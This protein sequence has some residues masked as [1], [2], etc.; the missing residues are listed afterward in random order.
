[1]S[2]NIIYL[3]EQSIFSET[4]K[5]MVLMEGGNFY[6]Y[7]SW[8]EIKDQFADL[9]ASYIF[10]DLD[11]F[12]ISTVSDEIKKIEAVFFTESDNKEYSWEGKL[13]IE[14]KPLDVL[15]FRKHLQGLV[16]G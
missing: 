8:D 16:D 15:L 2:K 7:K 10:I 14:T 1:M 12:D 11:T 5:Q 4:V 3:G 13:H 9:K 6:D